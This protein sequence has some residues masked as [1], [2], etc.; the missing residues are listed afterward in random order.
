MSQEISQNPQNGIFAF[1]AKMVLKLYKLWLKSNQYCNIKAVD[2]K[3]RY[4]DKTDGMMKDNWET[5]EV[6]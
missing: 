2:E 5:Y 3:Y 4:A 6:I 1:N